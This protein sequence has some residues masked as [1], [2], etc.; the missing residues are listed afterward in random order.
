MG[1]TRGLG[2]D[3]D[4]NDNTIWEQQYFYLDFDNDGYP[5]ADKIFLNGVELENK[6]LMLPPSVIGWSLSPPLQDGIST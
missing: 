6:K 5:S 2:I 4:D 3:C 1:T